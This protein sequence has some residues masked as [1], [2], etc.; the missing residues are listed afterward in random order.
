MFM[1][2]VHRVVVSDDDKS[3]LVV[4]ISLKTSGTR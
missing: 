3:L 1:R 4:L 2:K